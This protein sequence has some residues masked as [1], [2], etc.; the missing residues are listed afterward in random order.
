M[1]AGPERARLQWE[2]V[3]AANGGRGVLLL[4]GNYGGATR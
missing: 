3:K 4:Y 2:A 1:F